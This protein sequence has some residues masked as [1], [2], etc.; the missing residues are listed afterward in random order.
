MNELILHVD[1]DSIRILNQGVR[2]CL[3]P[4]DD[5]EKKSGFDSGISVLFKYWCQTND[6]EFTQKDLD[7]MFSLLFPLFNLLFSMGA[8]TD[9]LLNN[10]AKEE[11][12]D[13]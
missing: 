7:M 8:T 10:A 9:Y 6:D 5:D 3:A 12:T 2:L 1:K 4:N 11:N 13:E